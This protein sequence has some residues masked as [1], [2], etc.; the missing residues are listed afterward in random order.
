L[1]VKNIEKKKDFIYIKII[2]RLFVQYKIFFIE[3][4][5][6]R[7]FL[8]SFFSLEQDTQDTDENILFFLKKRFS[9]KKKQTKNYLFHLLN[10]IITKLKMKIF[11]KK[12]MIILKQYLNKIKKEEFLFFKKNKKGIFVNKQIKNLFSTRK[13]NLQTLQ[14]YTEFTFLR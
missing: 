8:Y 14:P 2:L 1:I 6:T 10:K 9:M 12:E 7:N 13:N 11:F 5:K 3:N 4:V